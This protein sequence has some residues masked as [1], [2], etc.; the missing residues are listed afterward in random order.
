MFTFRSCCQQQKAWLMENCLSNIL[1]L[2]AGH[3]V[4]L[5]EVNSQ[6]HLHQF[7]EVA[8]NLRNSALNVNKFTWYCLAVTLALIIILIRSPSCSFFSF[9][10]LSSLCWSSSALTF[11][12]LSAAAFALMTA[13]CPGEYSR[14]HSANSCMPS[15]NKIAHQ[16]VTRHKAVTCLSPSLL[17]RNWAFWS[18]LTQSEQP[19]L[20]VMYS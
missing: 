5:K 8:K 7:S 4:N 12:S 18:S 19:W 3:Q 13:S 17:P 15:K 6:K 14:R 9:F 1:F 2:S 20:A 16:K 10:S 11:P